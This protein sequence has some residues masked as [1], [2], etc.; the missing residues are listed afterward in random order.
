[1]QNMMSKSREPWWRGTRG[2][3]YAVGQVVLMGLVF[4]GPRHYSGWSLRPFPIP[5]ICTSIGVGLLLFGTALLVAG[6]RRLGANLTPLPYPK[7]KANLIES[8]PYRFV[9]H[10]MYSGGAAIAFG[11]ALFVQSWFTLLYA[12]ILAVFLDIKSRQEERWLAMK[13][14]GYGEYQRRVRRLIPF[15]Y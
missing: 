7:E 4:F 1:M 15:I 14:P 10:P 3:W 9:R 2:E 13:Y 8:G 12:L 5:T 11:W 6:F